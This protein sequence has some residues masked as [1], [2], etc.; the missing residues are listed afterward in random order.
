MQ[1]HCEG[2]VQERG[3]PRILTLADEAQ[4]LSSIDDLARAGSNVDRKTVEDM[5]RHASPASSVI[6]EQAKELYLKRHGADK[7]P[8]TISANWFRT[9]RQRNAAKL[10]HLSV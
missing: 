1:V 9:F 7:D 5:V 2:Q 8:S 3:R 6:A 10:A 4:L